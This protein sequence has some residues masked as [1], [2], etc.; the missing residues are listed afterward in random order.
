LLLGILGIINQ[1]CHPLASYGSKIHYYFPKLAQGISSVP[2][3]PGLPKL[4]SVPDG[5][6]ML[7]SLWFGP[8]RS[9]Q[10]TSEALNQAGSCLGGARA[11]SIPLL[12]D[13]SGTT[14]A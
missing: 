13:L 10:E 14:L 8:S 6:G 7:Y 4:T 12:P 9:A 1:F 5:G 3:P 2:A 11:T